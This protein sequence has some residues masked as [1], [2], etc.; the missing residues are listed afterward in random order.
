MKRSKIRET[1][2][3]ILFAIK[4]N[5]ATDPQDLYQQLRQQYETM[6]EMM[7]EYLKELITGVQQQL[8]QI[9]QVIA[10]YLKKGWSLERLNKTDLVIMQIAVF[11]IRFV[12]ETPNKV[13][14]NEALELARKFSD[15]NARRFINGVLSNLVITD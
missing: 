3:Q 9:N 4:S 12:K 7:P 13:A 15:E 6:P 14:V 5:P 10:T 1:A 11:E 8:T 2:F